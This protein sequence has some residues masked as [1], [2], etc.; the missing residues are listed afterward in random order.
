V[1]IPLREQRILLQK[2]GNRC[3]FP[4]CQR[5]L[6]AEASLPDRPAVLGE[7]AHIVAESP[8]GPRG[9]SPL[10][11]AERN[12]YENLILLC[13]QHHQLV[14]SQPQ[15]Y[16][17]E[18]LL[19][20]KE[21]H[22]RWVKKTLGPT[23]GADWPAEMRPMMAETVYST[24]L[25]VERLPRYV[26]GVACSLM[27]ER[28]VTARLRPLRN[29]EMA[30]FILRAGMLFTFQNLNDSRGPFSD[31]VPGRSAERYETIEW[32]DDSDRLAWFMTLMNRALNKLTGRRG[33]MLD[34]AHGRY[35]FRPNEPGQESVI[36]YR[37]LNQ[38]L[39]SRKVV[40]QPRSKR[41]GEGR[42]YWYHRA[43]SLRFLRIG[44]SDWCL[45]VRPELHVTLD[46]VRPAPSGEIGGKVTRK[47]SRMF[48]Y[49]LL[50]EV[51]F[52]RDYL[53]D[54]RPRI[55]LPFGPGQH[56]VISTTLMIGTVTWPGIP[57]EHAKPFKNVRYVDDMFSWAEVAGLDAAEG[58]RDEDEDWNEYGDPE[59]Q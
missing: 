39:A 46:G 41:T 8:D 33:L 14:D 31:L 34:R 9:A 38:R 49:D 42:G 47:K 11:A 4:R 53:S 20:M 17:V 16:I 36:R 23:D 26:Y 43:V 30:P 59:E 2:S 13:N 28:D 29:G 3:A 22:E 37:P 19:A 5:V 55:I 57:E 25:P 18:R 7:I 10:P 51:N 27:H 32:C 52:W 15:T 21:D 1:A 45:S 50:S 48:N 58:E 24:L 56:I 6:T 44:P 12:R 40:W 54:R 35:Y